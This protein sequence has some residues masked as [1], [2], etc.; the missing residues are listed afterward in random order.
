MMCEN[1]AFITNKISF[2]LALFQ[3]GAKIGNLAQVR[4]PLS[5]VL[6]RISGYLQ[7]N[8]GI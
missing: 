2:G 4:K 3:A 7:G 6:V 5:P 1:K 8:S